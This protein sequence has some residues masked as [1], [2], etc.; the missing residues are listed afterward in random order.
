MLVIK[1]SRKVGRGL[2]MGS[3]RYNG[4]VTNTNG[5]FYNAHS[6]SS[7]LEL[8]VAREGLISHGTCYYP[9]I[10]KGTTESLE[11]TPKCNSIEED[12]ISDEGESIDGENSDETMEQIV[13]SGET[14]VKRKRFSAS[15][16]DSIINGTTE[17]SS[18]APQTKIMCFDVSTPESDEQYEASRRAEVKTSIDMNSNHTLSKIPPAE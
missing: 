8:E 10:C 18:M 4:L 7:I 9:R 17:E 13:S 12:H 6:P 11:A 1:P 16:V 5:K 2:G 14:G 15:F 3:N